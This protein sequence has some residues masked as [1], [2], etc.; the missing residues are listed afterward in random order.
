MMS[1]PLIR[2][3]IDRLIKEKRQIVELR[4]ELTFERMLNELGK[5]ALADRITVRL[6]DY[7][8][9]IKHTNRGHTI[10]CRIQELADA[11]RALARNSKEQHVQR[12]FVEHALE[13]KFMA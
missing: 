7:L 4:H 13:R 1:N 6:H 9:E 3:E 12:K 8:D 10:Q 5:I 11:L 2:K